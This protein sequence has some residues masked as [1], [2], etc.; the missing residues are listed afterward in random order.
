LRAFGIDRD[1]EILKF[2]KDNEII[3]V[4]NRYINKDALVEFF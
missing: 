4:K 1:E 3:N 2:F